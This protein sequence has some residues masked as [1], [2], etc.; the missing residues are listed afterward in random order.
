MYAPQ[1]RPSLKI[2]LIVEEE[3]VLVTTNPEARLLDNIDHVHVDWGPD[4]ALRYGIGFPEA[5][6]SLFVNLGPLGLDYILSAGGSGYFRMHAVQSHMASGRLHLVPA[7]PQ[8]SYPVYA[9]YS[10]NADDAVFGR[11]WPVCAPS[12]PH[13]S[14]S[15]EF[16]GRRHG[17]RTIAPSWLEFADQV[18]V[19]E[20]STPLTPRP[21]SARRVVSPF[22]R[23]AFAFCEA[24]RVTAG[25]PL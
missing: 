3:L 14:N 19:C 4:F 13:V 7:A 16:A 9:V 5:T 23:F 24:R 1:H 15:S 25:S 18:L 6:P 10:A 21:A 12:R 8:F 2:D 22:L 11:L 17:G 20:Q